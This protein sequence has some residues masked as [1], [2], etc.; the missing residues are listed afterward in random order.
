M[1]GTREKSPGQGGTLLASGP[2]KPGTAHAKNMR[3]GKRKERKRESGVWLCMMQ[4]AAGQVRGNT[5]DIL[6]GEQ[7]GALAAECSQMHRAY[8]RQLCSQSSRTGGGAGGHS[9]QHEEDRTGGVWGGGGKSSVRSLE[10]RPT[11]GMHGEQV[12]GRLVVTGV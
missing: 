9:E 12:T 11:P 2:R 7:R 6:P 10:T 1:S 8:I 4:L 3:N 5:A